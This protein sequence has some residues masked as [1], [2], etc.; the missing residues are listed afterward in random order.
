MVHI[1]GIFDR[2]LRQATETAGRHPGYVAQ[3]HKLTTESDAGN[4]PSGQ[5]IEGAVVVGMRSVR[6]VRF[7]RAKQRGV[8]LS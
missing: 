3:C 6:H 4:T 2:F 8:L 1:D 5:E 7:E